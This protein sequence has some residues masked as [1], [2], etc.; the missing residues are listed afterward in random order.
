M[1]S[2]T[3]D[4]EL[5]VVRPGDPAADDDAVDD[6]GADAVNTGF[7]VVDAVAVALAVADCEAAGEGDPEAGA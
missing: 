3:A 6:A 7:D 4:S 1:G 5:E 2:A